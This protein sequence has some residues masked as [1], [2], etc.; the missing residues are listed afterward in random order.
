MYSLGDFLDNQGL[1]NTQIDK[2]KDFMEEHY[3]LSEDTYI[4]DGKVHQIGRNSFDLY[5]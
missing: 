4:Y 3:C 1:S 5:G 2:I